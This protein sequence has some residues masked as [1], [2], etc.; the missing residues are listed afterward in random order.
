MHG[1]HM[2]GHSDEESEVKFY[3]KILISRLMKFMAP[4]KYKLIFALAL[5][6]LSAVYAMITP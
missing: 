2:H 5:M 1:F 6:L 3:D 4:H